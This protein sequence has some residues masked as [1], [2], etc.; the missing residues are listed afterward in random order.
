MTI[1]EIERIRELRLAG[2]S[3]TQIGS[4]MCLSR[5]TV[6]SACRRNGILSAPQQGQLAGE[7][8]NVCRQ[9]SRVITQGVS[10]KP[11]R[12]CSEACRRQW[13][14]NHRANGKRKTAVQYTCAFCGRPFEDYAKSQRKYCRH[15]C[16]VKAR[17][18][19]KATH[20]RRTARA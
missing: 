19:G 11:K 10:G 4:Q 8:R 3:Y 1:Q 7:V 12:F 14:N 15:D 2:K 17:F 5:D 20:D 6:K 13:W 16:Y 18:G 9:C